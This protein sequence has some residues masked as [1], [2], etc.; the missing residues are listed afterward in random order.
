MYSNQQKGGP[1]APALGLSMNAGLI[2]PLT[3][4]PEAILSSPLAKQVCLIL[5]FFLFKKLLSEFYYIYS[6]ATIITTKLYRISIPNPQGIPPPSNLSPLKPWYFK[7]HD[8]VTVL[9][10]SSLCPFFEIPHVNDIAFDV[11]VSLT[12]FT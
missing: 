7:V 3:Q 11:G 8:S 12:D 10:R 2:P 1:Q 6:C 4:R 9:Q 5:F